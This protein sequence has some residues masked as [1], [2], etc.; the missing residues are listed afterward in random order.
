MRNPKHIVINGNGLQYLVLMPDAFHK[1]LCYTLV[2]DYIFEL[3]KVF[4]WR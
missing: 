1:V 4:L 2:V 3:F